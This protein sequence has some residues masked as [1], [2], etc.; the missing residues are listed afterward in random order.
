MNK[1]IIYF[2]ILS[3]LSACESARE[4]FTLKKKDNSDEFLVEK[5]NPLVMPPNYENLPKPE[6]FQSSEQKKKE[7]EFQKIISN[8]K[9]NTISTDTKNS[10]L[11]DSIIEKIN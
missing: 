10:S 11:K 3:F 4:G 1:L 8:N 9:N 6:D 2:L 7:D 5:K